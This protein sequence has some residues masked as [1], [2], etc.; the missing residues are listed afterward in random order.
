MTLNEIAYNIKNIVEGGISGEDSTLSIRQIKAMVNYHRA[1]LLA[2]YTKFGK[3]LSKAV[4]QTVSSNLAGGWFEI[5]AIVG[6]EKNRGIGEIMLRS[7]AFIPA[8]EQINIP[9]INESERQFFESSRFAPSGDK[10]YATL[11]YNAA[12]V[13]IGATSGTESMIH[14]YSG[15]GEL[16]QDE[17]WT[18][19]VSIIASNPSN[20]PGFDDATSHYP[21]PDE[22]ISTLIKTVLSVEFTIYLKT[23]A[24]LTNNSANDG[25]SKYAAKALAESKSKK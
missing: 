13:G 2:D 15:E 6:F 25:N 14:I 23:D 19:Y 3:S 12:A 17:N 11:S 18:A 7:E 9:I 16:F 5:P 21:L 20:V 4:L 22:L 1:Q 10:Y 24:D 8:E